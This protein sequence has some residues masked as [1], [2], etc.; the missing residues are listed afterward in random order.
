MVG[1]SKQ[2]SKANKYTHVKCSNA[3]VELAQARPNKGNIRPKV[4]GRCTFKGQN[5]FARLQ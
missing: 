1:P 5:S 3:S 2:A 4:G